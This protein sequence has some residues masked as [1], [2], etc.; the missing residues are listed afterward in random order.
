MSQGGSQKIKDI[1]KKENTKKQ[2]KLENESEIKEEKFSAK[3]T[4][5]PYHTL[6][7]NFTKT[8]VVI[9]IQRGLWTSKLLSQTN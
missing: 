8:I 3:Q 1:T 6:Q 2:F 9:V 5:E 4:I 7:V